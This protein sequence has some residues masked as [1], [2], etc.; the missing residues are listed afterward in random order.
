MF[1]ESMRL[2]RGELGGGVAEVRAAGE[3][4]DLVAGQA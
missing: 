4:A 3:V 2:V 1:H